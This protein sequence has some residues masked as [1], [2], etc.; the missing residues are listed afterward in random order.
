MCDAA[1]AKISQLNP[2]EVAKIGSRSVKSQD[3]NLNIEFTEDE[4]K[5]EVESDIGILEGYYVYKIL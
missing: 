2:K 5:D 4:E 1:Q 3:K